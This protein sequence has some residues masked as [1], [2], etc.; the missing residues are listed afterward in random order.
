MQ[1]RVKLW[2]TTIGYISQEGYDRIYFQYDKDFLQ[3][4]IE[5]SPIVMPLSA[6][7]YSF[8]TL[9]ETTF[10]GLAGLFS[11]SLPDKFGTTVM[12]R[13]LESQGK[14]LSDLTTVEKL[15][16]T[17]TR[18]MGALEYEPHMM[19]HIPDEP[20]DLDALTR[21]AEAILSEKERLHIS[22][23]DQMMAQLL[24]TSSSIGGAR[25]KALI[26]WNEKTGEI[27]SGQ[28]DAGSGYDY[29]ILKFDGITNNKDHD[30]APD[31]REH[32]KI[33]YAY[34]L[35]AK[36]AGIHMSEC[37]LY[38]EHGF[39]HFLTKR[40]DRIST[41]GEKL[42]MQSLGSLAHFDFKMPRTNSYEEAIFIMRRLHLGQDEVTQFF[43]RM[44]F[45]ECAMNYDDHVKNISFLMDKSGQWH[46]SPAYDLTFS[47]KPQ[48]Q[49][50][51]AHQMLIN[52]KAEHITTEDILQ[53]AKAADI[54]T[55]TAQKIIEQTALA[56]SN[57]ENYAQQAGLA[58]ENMHRIQKQLRDAAIN[59][60]F[61]SNV[62][63]S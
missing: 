29:W 45:N 35:M 34:S 62:L 51:S 56:V 36:A 5:L 13:Y 48:S 7:T 4:G 27:R 9:S 59:Q 23:N 43:R 39:S 21:L 47:Y 12:A 2:G 42:H 1:V 26:S 55:G 33:E 3:S 54:R 28:I 15:C 19:E 53:V 32:T 46:L 60:H 17:G 38:E 52:A 8:P 58:E 25:A 31:E 16:Y 49:W 37:R 24:K 20:I 10:Y 57:W 63:T 6:R 11:E 18:G 50:V 41:S 22:K 61:L 14:L 30:L 40:F 44:V